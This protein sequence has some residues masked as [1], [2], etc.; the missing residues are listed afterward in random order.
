MNYDAMNQFDIDNLLLMVKANFGMPWDEAEGVNDWQFPAGFEKT[1]IQ[2]VVE[3]GYSFRFYDYGPA[4]FIEPFKAVGMN[5][6]ADFLVTR[7]HERLI[8]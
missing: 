4:A 5:R 7:S 1:F 2:S 3:S 6:I 8:P